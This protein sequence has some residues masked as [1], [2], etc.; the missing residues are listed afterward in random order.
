MRI[1]L[2]SLGFALLVT[3]ASAGPA[4]AQDAYVYY[5][6][7]PGA[8]DL[9]SR[10]SYTRSGRDAGQRQTGRPPALTIP[11]RSRL[12]ITVEAGNAALYSYSIAATKLAADTVAGLGEL[13]KQLGELTDLPRA[14]ALAERQRQSHLQQLTQQQFQP[15]VAPQS[16]QPP[17]YDAY[18]GPVAHL[19]AQFMQMQAHQLASDTVSDFT[20]AAAEMARRASEAADTNRAAIAALGDLRDTTAPEVRLIRAVHADTW[21]RI[22][23]LDN[24]FRHALETAN[25]ALCTEVETSRLRVTLKIARTVADSSGRS[26]RPVGDTVLTLDVNPSDGR[27]FLIEP[28]MLL[29]AFTQDKSIISVA[30]DLVAQA[31]DHGVG[32]HAGVFAMA[33]AGSIRWLWVTVGA[34][35]A[36]NAV[37]DVF[38][39]ITLRGGASLVGGRI[40]AGI[41]LALSRVPVGVSQGAVDSALPADVKNVDDVIR[42]EFRPGLG[43]TFAIQVP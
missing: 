15:A 17:P 38:I 36:D 23:V 37:S 43:V 41:G 2:R 25:D 26:Q 4:V 28:G 35:T 32:V 31:S 10:L 13:I 40:S 24:R 9:Q 30:D 6:H 34:A 11:S 3:L 42:R 33:R 29:S 18:L 5:N 21:N 27:S 20:R 7:H 14:R 1:R 16:A 12:C 8:G 22:G 19:Y 39:G